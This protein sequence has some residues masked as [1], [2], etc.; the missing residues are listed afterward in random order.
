MVVVQKKKGKWR[1][2]VDYTD[3]KKA[4]PKDPFPLA[5]I[6]SM[7]DATAGHELLTF[8]DDLVVFQQIQMEPSDQEDTAFITP[9]GIYRYTVMPLVLKMQVRYIKDW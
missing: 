4:C 7:I 1:V 5:H 3:H 2:C 8:M 6:A 9:I